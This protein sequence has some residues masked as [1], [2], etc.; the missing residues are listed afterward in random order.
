M[1][2]HLKAA[3]ADRA[4]AAPMPVLLF[5]DVDEL[6]SRAT[7]ELLKACDFVD[8]GAGGRGQTLHLGMR[9]YV[10]SYGWEVGGEAASWR[11]SATVWKDG[12]KGEGEY[13]RHGKQTER[14]L[15]DSGWHCS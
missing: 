14:V 4:R 2:R 12:G 6:P 3:L 7:V 9:E 13:Y 5:A 15:V 10:Y 8:E 1:D 11:A